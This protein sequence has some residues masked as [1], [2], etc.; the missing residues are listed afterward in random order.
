MVEHA[1]GTEGL[2]VVGSSQLLAEP[3]IR[4]LGDL[5]VRGGVTRV[6][7]F[8]SLAH[9]IESQSA[10]IGRYCEFA[11]D[12][13]IGATGHPLTWLGVN[14]FQYKKATWGWHP[15]ADRS[16]VID[17]EAGGR[18]SFRGEPSVVGNDV[19]IGAK[20]VILRGVTIGDGAV[21]AAGAV[22]A[23]DVAPYSIVGGVPARPIRDRV[24]PQTRERLQELAW[25]RFSPN[26]LA[27]VTFDDLPRALDQLDERVSGLEPY[28]PG[29]VPIERPVATGS[30]RSRWRR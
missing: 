30:K 7:A 12:V 19:W 6:G 2:R 23:D 21:V 20:V 29:F 15:S 28:E 18:P 3:P 27:G 4:M 14:S 24:D 17:P 26:Q 13:L 11:P 8:T 22:V 10:T 25:W 16:E 5:L 1:R 9:G